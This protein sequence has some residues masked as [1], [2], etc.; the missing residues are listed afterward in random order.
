MA[1]EGICVNPGEWYGQVGEAEYDWIEHDSGW[2]GIDLRS[3]GYPDW[4]ET[5]YAVIS[6]GEFAGQDWWSGTMMSVPLPMI[7]VQSVLEP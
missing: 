4:Y 5:S 7:E 2:Y 3:Y 6:G 1:P